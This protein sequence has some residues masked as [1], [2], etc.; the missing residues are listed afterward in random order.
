MEMEAQ[1]QQECVC[2][3]RCKWCKGLRFPKYL[4][5]EALYLSRMHMKRELMK[6]CLR[7]RARL[8]EINSNRSP[9]W[10]SLEE[11]F[12]LT[13]WESKKRNGFNKCCSWCFPEFKQIIDSRDLINYGASKFPL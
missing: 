4:V 1:L 6:T 9:R 11:A 3:A 5:V 7:E 13:K 8:Y 2:Q 12:F 10:F